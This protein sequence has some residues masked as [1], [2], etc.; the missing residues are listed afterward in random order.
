MIILITLPKLRFLDNIHWWLQFMKKWNGDK[1]KCEGH[2]KSLV[3]QKIR[4]LSV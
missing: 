3:F 4:L 1:K 2:K